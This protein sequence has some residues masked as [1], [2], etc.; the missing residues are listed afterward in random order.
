M[1]WGQLLIASRAA[2]RQALTLVDGVQGDATV[3]AR[4]LIALAHALRPQLRG[5]AAARAGLPPR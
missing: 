5:G 3:L 4:R 1:L 2:V